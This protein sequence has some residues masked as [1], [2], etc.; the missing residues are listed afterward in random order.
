MAA[1]FL[2]VGKVGAGLLFDPGFGDVSQADHLLERS[3]QLPGP[4]FHARHAGGRPGAVLPFGRRA[5]GGG[6]HGRGRPRGL[7]RSHGLGPDKMTISTPKRRRTIPIWQMVDIRLDEIF[8][9][10]AHRP[11]ARRTAAHG[12]GVAA[13][14]LA[15]VGPAGQAARIRNRDAVGNRPGP[16][17]AARHAKKA[18]A[19]RTE[20]RR[21][22]ANPKK[23]LAPNS[24]SVIVDSVDT[25]LGQ[26]EYVFRMKTT[27]PTRWIGSRRVAELAERGLRRAAPA[28]VGP[29]R[30]ISRGGAR[31]GQF[32]LERLSRA[33]RRL[34][35][36]GRRRGPPEPKAGARRQ[37]AG[38]RPGRGTSSA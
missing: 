2:L 4:Q 37:S 3:A 25:N 30:S 36:A 31:A 13:H 19:K 15:A 21:R 16:A 10:R 9:E 24:Y 26:V 1:T 38:D 8:P 23:V 32:R 5:P 34:G 22:Q 14:R 12:H 35:C 28:H 17:K 27:P 29:Q 33:G 7:S 6:R 18:K 11:A 20:V